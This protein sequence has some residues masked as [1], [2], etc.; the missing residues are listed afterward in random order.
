MAVRRRAEA[1]P[2]GYTFE[3]VIACFCSLH[4]SPIPAFRPR[5][6][7]RSRALSPTTRSRAAAVV[8][9][10]L[11]DACIK[12]LLTLNLCLLCPIAENVKLHQVGLAANVGPRRIGL[13]ANVGPHRIGLDTS[14]RPRRIGLATNV[15]PHRI[16]LAANVMPPR[17]GLAANVMPP[18]ISLVWKTPDN[19]QKATYHI[20]LCI[21]VD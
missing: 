18:R 2:K 6:G 10:A 12:C 9:K 4:V 20:N 14:V 11:V 17:I 15:M 13:A 5:R 16:G 7:T 3:G 8:R 1:A 21:N 19:L